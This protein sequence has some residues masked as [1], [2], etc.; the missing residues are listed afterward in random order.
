MARTSR[1]SNGS[2]IISVRDKGVGLPQ[3]FNLKSG[4]GLGMRLVDSFSQ[5]LQADLQVIR[6]D[7]GTEFI[8]TLPR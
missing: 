1:G 8:V 6:R 7:L 2:I 3:A 4:R 5:Q